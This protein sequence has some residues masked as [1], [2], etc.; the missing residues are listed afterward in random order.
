MLNKSFELFLRF[1]DID[2]IVYVYIYIFFFYILH[3]GQSCL[4]YLFIVGYRDLSGDRIK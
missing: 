1:L 2:L 3:V 4:K